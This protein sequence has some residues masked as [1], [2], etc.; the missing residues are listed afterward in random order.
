MHAKENN[1]GQ[2]AAEKGGSISNESKNQVQ[3]ITEDLIASLEAENEE[4]VNKEHPLPHMRLEKILAYGAT[5]AV[6]KGRSKSGAEY[7]VKI[8]LTVTRERAQ[9]AKKE[10]LIHK[11]MKHQNI[12]RLVGFHCNEKHTYLIMPLAEKNELFS[13]IEPGRGIKE[14]MCRMY[15]QQLLAALTYI[16]G[17][18]V[19]HRD[20]K[21]ENILLDKNY[22]LLLSDFGYSTLYV[23]DNGRRVLKKTCGSPSYAAPEMYKGEYD[24]EKADVWSF[25]MVCLVMLTGVVPWSEPLVSDRVFA[26]FRLQPKKEI[27][28]FNAV[29]KRVVGLVRNM[30]SID[31]D[32]RPGFADLARHPWL[33]EKSEFLLPDGC[34]RNPK[35]VAKELSGSPSDDVQ[36]A[37][38]QP[39]AC[40]YTHGRTY[41][42]Q[43]VF[44]SYDDTHEATRIYSPDRLPQALKTVSDALMALLIN[45]RVYGESITFATVDA[46]KSPISGSIQ[47]QTIGGGTLAVFQ[48]TRGNCLEFKKMFNAIKSRTMGAGQY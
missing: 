7:A 21:P 19:C 26:R 11:Q 12:I 5:A 40:N 36:F 30:L 13:Y 9:A 35:T 32:E 15:M 18:G 2:T 41:A 20:I 34:I 43:P 31:P 37:F 23:S 33:S 42:S 28:P 24:G 46:N 48:R 39:D 38:S 17:R 10:A 25:G 22:N 6:R 44:M 1:P 47:F 8:M 4:E 45:Y 29:P 27:P 3:K 16:H 14:N